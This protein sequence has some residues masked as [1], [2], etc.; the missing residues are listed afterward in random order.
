MNDTTP[1]HRLVR[2]YLRALDSDCAV[3]PASYARELREQIRAHLDDA[4]GPEAGEQEVAET[5]RQLGS[6]RSLVAEAAA[7]AGKRPWPARLTWRGWLATAAAVIAVAG[8]PGYVTFAETRAPLTAGGGSWWSARDARQSVSASAGNATQVTAPVRSGQE[9]GFYVFLFNPSGQAQTVL[10]VAAGYGQS[11]AQSRVHISLSVVNPYFTHGAAAQ[12][13]R[14]RLPVSIPPGQTRYL[15]VLWL[16]RGCIEKGAEYGLG[17]VVL[18]VRIGLVTRTETVPLDR[19]YALGAG[20][21][22]TSGRQP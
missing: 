4:L 17:T 18:R 21:P 8:V 13:L 12:A 10:G 20:T 2:D 7:T 19:D 15:R 22:C 3:L 16:S 1:Q 6:P 5:L 14:Y 9:Q 11:P